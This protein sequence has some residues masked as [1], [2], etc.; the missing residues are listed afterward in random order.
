LAIPDRY[1]RAARWAVAHLILVSLLGTLLGSAR[2]CAWTLLRRLQGR[3]LLPLPAG[4]PGL[5]EHPTGRVLIWAVHSF[6]VWFV[7]CAALL[8]LGILLGV[9]VSG[10][11]SAAKGAIAKW[12]LYATPILIPALLLSVG[13]EIWREEPYLQYTRGLGPAG[14]LL[15]PWGSPSPWVLAVVYSLWWALGVATNPYLPR[16]GW[17]VFLAHLAAY[18]VAWTLLRFVLFRAGALETLL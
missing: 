4:T 8:L 3:T 14:I 18:P 10:R 9:C 15:A 6:G 7:V 5:E 17:R 16:R 11:H 1:G 12:S 2:Y 13:M